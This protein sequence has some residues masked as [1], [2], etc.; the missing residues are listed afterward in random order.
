VR[1]PG[2]CVRCS[3]PLD[4]ESE[5]GLCPTCRIAIDT[6]HSSAE[7]P[8]PSAGDKTASFRLAVSKNEPATG[9]PAGTATRTAN[10]PSID[11]H[12]APSPASGT[13]PDPRRWSCPSIDPQPGLP[14][15]PLGYELIVELDSGG[16]GVVYLARDHVTDRLVAMKFLR[17]GL[18]GGS[19]A[20]RFLVEVRALAALNHPNIVRVL[21]T[22]FYRPDPF[23]TMD[24][25]AGG[26]LADVVKKHGPLSAAEAVALMRPVVGAVA[27]AHAENIL[28][29]DLK[30]SNI[31]LGADGTP[32]VSDFGLAKRTDKDDGITIN[33]VSLG[34][35]G[36]MPPEQISRRKGVVGPASDV[37]GLGATL[38]HLLTGQPPFRGGTAAETKNQVL[39]DLP[40]R[41]RALRPEVPLALEAVVMKCLEKNP[42]DR[43]PSAEAL[44]NDLDRFQVGLLPDAP[45]LTRPRRAWHWLRRNRVRVAGGALALIAVVVLGAI[46]WPGPEPAEQLRRALKAGKSYT[47]VPETGP[48]RYYRWRLGGSAFGVSPMP[49]K[50]CYYESIHHVTLLEL[51]PEDPGTDRY[52]VTFDL[53]HYAPLG[54]EESAKVDL[55]FVA[56]YWGHAEQPAPDGRP[57]HTFFALSYSDT[58]PTPGPSPNYFFVPTSTALI[59]RPE[60]KPVR[61]QKEIGARCPFSGSGSSPG[62]WRSFRV[63]VTPDRVRVEW[64]NDDTGD[65]VLLSEL[66]GEKIQQKYAGTQTQPDFPPGAVVPAWSPRMP[67]GIWL[68]RGAVAVKN[69]VITPL[70]PASE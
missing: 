11:L 36:Y 63:D 61:V 17:G 14:P 70:N 6:P 60:D 29:R 25:E 51:S 52:R 30:P 20:D 1:S 7:S 27:A 45:L 23:F 67:M 65:Y 57:I 62:K 31:L 40:Q 15:A 68:S 66:T 59:L 3:Q 4:T 48:P 44:A 32:K 10:A 41:P 39:T 16:M 54:G 47:V 28:H 69:F 55:S 21:S 12:A 2:S 49:E 5:S 46:F 24:Y 33:S 8:A 22:D 50:S 13:L 53:Q 38:Y 9:S 19:A 58:K 37:Y 34:T 18:G 43:Y 56:F 26:T 35:P 64:K 42:A